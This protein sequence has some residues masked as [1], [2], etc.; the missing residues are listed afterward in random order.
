MDNKFFN[1]KERI[2]YLIEYNNDTRE[3]FFNKIG[4]TYGAFKGNAKNRPLNSDAIVNILSI[5]TNISSF[6][7]LTGK[8]NMLLDGSVIEQKEP[9]QQQKEVVVAE[10]EKCK[11][12]ERVIISQQKTICLLEDKIESLE[13]VEGFSQKKAG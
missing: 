9:I 2:L 11:E 4:M 7:L 6:W 13:N 3:D 12:K 8:G 5:Y 1:I 10:C